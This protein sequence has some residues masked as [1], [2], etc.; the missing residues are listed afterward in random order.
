MFLAVQGTAA[1]DIFCIADACMMELSPTPALPSGIE[2]NPW[3][4]PVLSR[5]DVLDSLL[6]WD[7]QMSL[8]VHA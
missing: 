8:T 3:S 5:R 7:L 4:F 2:I 6:N 1:P